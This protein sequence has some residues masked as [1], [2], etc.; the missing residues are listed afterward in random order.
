MENRAVRSDQVVEYE[1]LVSTWMAAHRHE[2]AR[3]VLRQ[4]LAKNESRKL[5]AMLGD[6]EHLA[7]DYTAALEAYGR[8]CALDPAF[9]RGW[10]MMG[11]CCQELGRPDEARAHLQKASAFPEQSASA[12]ILLAE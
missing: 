5:W 10:L 12:R 9:G 4:A 3:T 7:E 1:R 8:G 6:L 11:Y 2:E